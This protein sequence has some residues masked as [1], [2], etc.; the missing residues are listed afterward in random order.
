M[1]EDILILED[2]PGYIRDRWSLVVIFA[3]TTT[4]LAAVLSFFIISPKYEAKTKLFIGKENSSEKTQNYNS[5]D[6]QMYQKLLKTYSDVILTD[7]LVESALSKKNIDLSTSDVLSKLSVTPKNDTQILEIS[8]VSK[9][10]NEAM[11]VVD[12]VTN[13]FIETSSTLIANANVK[14]VQNVKLPQEPI[15]PN[16]KLNLLIGIVL[17]IVGGCAIAVFLGLN[18]NTFKDKNQ[19]ESLVELPVIGTIPNSDIIK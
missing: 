17:G 11:E 2:I 3:L 4:I 12:A 14:I 1:D 19:V 7:D 5:N 18:D 16:K 15:S 10:K 13:K 9:D 8:Y 6:I